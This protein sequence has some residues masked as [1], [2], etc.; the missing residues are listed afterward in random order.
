M[1]MHRFGGLAGGP[2]TGRAIWLRERNATT[3]MPVY[4]SRLRNLWRLR[5]LRRRL[6]CDEYFALGAHTPRMP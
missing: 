4:M 1:L 2:L 5:A 6:L 3:V